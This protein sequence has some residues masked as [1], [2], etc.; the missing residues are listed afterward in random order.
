MLVGTTTALWGTRQ[1]AQTWS[2]FKLNAPDTWPEAR[3]TLVVED[4]ELGQV[5]VSRWSTFHFR[6]AAEQAMEVLRV[7][8]LKPV[9]RKRKFKPLW[10]VWLGQTMPSLD[11]LWWKYLRRFAV[12]HWYRFAKQ[13]LHWTLPQVGETT[14]AERWSDLMPVMSWQL[15]IAREDCVDHPLPWQKAQDNLSPGR[16]AQLFAAII[17]SIGTPAQP[18]KTRG[19]S[20]GWPKGQPR[21]ARTRYPT[22]KKRVSKKKKTEKTSKPSSP[23]VA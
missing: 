8:V 18:P 1:T 12:D 22:V 4:P 3:E 16:V 5:K 20:P 6:Q 13:R 17:A 11:E 9:G 19:K 2:K 23:V 10:L 14:A 15:W 21:S 7:E